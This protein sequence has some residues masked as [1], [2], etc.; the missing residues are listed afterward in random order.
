MITPKNIAGVV[1]LYNPEEEVLHCIETYSDQID[2]IYAVDNSDAPPVFTDKIKR[3][4]NIEYISLHG[5]FG[6]AKALNVAAEKA[7]IEGYPFLL[8]M[9]QDSKATP[10]MVATLLALGPIT[11]PDLG[12]LSPFHSIPVQS[13]PPPGE[14]N[15]QQV[16]T[17]WTSG[18]LLNL[19]AYKKVGPFNE[20]YFIDFVD[21]EYGMRLNMAGYKTYKINKAI[22]QH[23]IGTDIHKRKFFWI[24]LVVSNHS[25]IRK[26]YITR[27]RFHL[28]SKMGKP[29]AQFFRN[30]R[31][32]FLADILTILFFEK[33]KRQKIMMIL[34]GYTDYKKSISGKYNR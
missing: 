10:D 28:A 2:K 5:N 21:H 31:K 20:D 3:I 19:N 9:D 34:R 23:N 29:F 33:E 18:S 16:L 22:L 4:K 15:C 11:D 25:P 14:P 1:V 12:M 6:I 17:A 24:E 7:I 13:F 26:Y 8:C 32:S 30:D 27:N